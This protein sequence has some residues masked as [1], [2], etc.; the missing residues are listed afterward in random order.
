MN[1]HDG[2]VFW[3]DLAMNPNLNS[4]WMLFGF[5]YVLAEWLSD[6]TVSACH[7]TKEGGNGEGR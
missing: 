6:S 2:M 5:S 1:W 3:C 4:E 7:M